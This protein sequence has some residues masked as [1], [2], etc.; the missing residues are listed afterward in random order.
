MDAGSIEQPATRTHRYS[1]RRAYHTLLVDDVLDVLRRLAVGGDEALALLGGGG[2]RPRR[3][4]CRLA[5]VEVHV[6]CL[7]LPPLVLVGDL[8]SVSGYLYVRSILLTRLPDARNLFVRMCFQPKLL[9][10]RP[11][12]L[13]F[14][15]LTV[16]H[17]LLV[18]VS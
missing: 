2:S 17:L 6:R 11:L 1:V 10:F 7:R 3:R 12:L 13:F 5:I 15:F 8:A 18:L 16:L 14:E 4:H 9:E